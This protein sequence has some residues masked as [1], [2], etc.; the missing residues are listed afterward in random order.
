MQLTGVDT[1]AESVASHFGSA[2]TM[3]EAS[4][5]DWVA[6]K[7]IGKVTAKQAVREINAHL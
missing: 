3:A 5:A 7:G 6:I 1:K 4:E 2:R